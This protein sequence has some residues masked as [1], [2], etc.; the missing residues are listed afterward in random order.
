MSPDR[1]P[2]ALSAR[3]RLRRHLA[4]LWAF[5]RELSGEAALERRMRA[6]GCAAEAP[7]AQRVKRA[8]CEAFDRPHRCC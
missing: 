3:S 7:D 8:W 4:R 5:A 1:P 6:C 2:P